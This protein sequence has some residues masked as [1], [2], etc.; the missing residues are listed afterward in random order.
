MISTS[1]VHIII[2]LRTQHKSYRKL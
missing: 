1:L 2:R